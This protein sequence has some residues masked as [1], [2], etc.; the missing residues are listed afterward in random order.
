LV[1]H[2]C[3]WDCPS[4]AASVVGPILAY[5]ANETIF[6]INYERGRVI[7]EVRLHR[8]RKARIM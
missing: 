1:P 6:F 7:K 3:N 4:S 5:P 8:I 2:G